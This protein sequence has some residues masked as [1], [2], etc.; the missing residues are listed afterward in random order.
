MRYNNIVRTTND[1]IYE[2]KTITSTQNKKLLLPF[3]LGFIFVAGTAGY[4]A[5]KSPHE[6]QAAWWGGDG[7]GPWQHRK[8]L[9]L[10]NSTT[11]PLAQYTTVGVTINTKELV[12]R[13]K[14]QEDCAD[15]RVVYQPNDSTTTELDRHI[16]YPGGNNCGTSEASNVYFSIQEGS[17]LGASSELS[18]YYMYYGNTSATAPTTPVDAFNIGSKNALLVCPF[19][20][21]TT[22]VNG[23]GTTEPTT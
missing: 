18:S 22:C 1:P 16:S 23:A 17:G 14:L 9:T 19:D 6:A 12:N 11:E 15:L 20:G 2:S 7:S 3:L 4:F 13:G 21:T 8:R 10:A 5:L